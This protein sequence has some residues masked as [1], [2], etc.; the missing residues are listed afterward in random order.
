MAR[1]AC[2][3][4]VQEAPI[5]LRHKRRDRLGV[6]GGS[7]GIAAIAG[8]LGFYPMP[9]GVL[10]AFAVWILGATLVIL[11]TS[12]DRIDRGLRE[13]AADHTARAVA[14]D[15]D[16]AEKQQREAEGQGQAFLEHAGAIDAGHELTF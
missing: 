2:D 16:R 7:G 13:G 15:D 9:L 6:I 4:W 8:L 1:Y 11:L 14:K 10:L 5:G 12:P 3:R